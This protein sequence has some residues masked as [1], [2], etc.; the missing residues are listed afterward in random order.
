VYFCVDF[1][2]IVE[3]IVRLAAVFAA[4]EYAREPSPGWAAKLLY[5]I[6]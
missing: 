2:P 3:V 1:K 4:V 6:G 5:V